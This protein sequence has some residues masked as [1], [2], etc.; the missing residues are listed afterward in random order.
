MTNWS[1]VKLIH[2]S[3]SKR[4]CEAGLLAA[5]VSPPPLLPLK[6]TSLNT[7]A[8]RH[9]RARDAVAMRGRSARAIVTHRLQ[10]AV[11]RRYTLVRRPKRSALHHRKRLAHPG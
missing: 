8:E 3:I 2:C 4:S 7:R 5:T 6:L 11:T 1:A 10:A 9:K